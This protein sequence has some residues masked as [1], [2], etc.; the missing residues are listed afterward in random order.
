MLLEMELDELATELRD[1]APSAAEPD[2]QGA[3]GSVDTPSSIQHR[4][5]YST[6]A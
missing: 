4:N 5:V 1:L 6:D 3:G 2:S